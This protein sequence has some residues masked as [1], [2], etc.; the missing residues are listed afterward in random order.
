MLSGPEGLAGEQST[1]LSSSWM[2][3][4]SPTQ[5]IRSPSRYPEV[6]VGFVPNGARYFHSLGRGLKTRAGAAAG[7]VLFAYLEPAGEMF[8]LM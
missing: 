2:R 8:V 1:G 3:F 4:R 6:A 5:P 7:T